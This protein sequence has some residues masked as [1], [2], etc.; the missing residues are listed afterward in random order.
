[1]VA[2]GRS[3]LFIALLVTG[4]FVAWIASVSTLTAQQ[5]GAGPGVRQIGTVKAI[6]NSTIVLTTD[7]GL[8]INLDVQPTSRLL[9]AEPGQKDLRTAVP[10]QFGEIQAGDRL[11]VRG[12]LSDDGKTLAA[13]LIV[14]IK[15]ASIEEKQA[16]EREDWRKR[17]LGGL[18]KEVDPVSH[19]VTITTSAL[20]GSKP[21]TV[22]FS[23][24]A[25]L[26]RYSP[27]SVRYE[28]AKP[29]KF[30]EIKAGDQF[31]GRGNRSADGKEF[32]AE[33]IITGSF[34]SIAGTISSIDADGKTLA[35]ADLI[36][37]HAVLV[38]ITGD[39]SL[40]RLPGHL[41]DMIAQQLEAGPNGGPPTGSPPAGAPQ[42]HGQPHGQPAGVRPPG[43]G[44]RDF[45]QMV[46]Q[47]PPTP[48]A[49]F[50]KGDAVMIVATSGNN[51]EEATAINLLGGVEPILRVSPEGG[52]EM[53]MTPWSLGGPAPAGQDQ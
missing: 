30:E 38:R 34:R 32:E 52:R 13:S 48:I 17:G 27:E 10:L 12:R 42:G 40:H 45:Q 4:S 3:S 43:N 7:S 24:D 1:M 46:A 20:A 9:R 23:P 47:L 39:T 11:L 49:D 14:A 33:E 53:I 26:R 51:P 29:G 41:A 6:H 25:I 22:R 8:E 37:K 19:T 5:P 16:H 28:D 44:L 31:R 36:T 18:V 50:P 21:V 35:V 15:K 2:K